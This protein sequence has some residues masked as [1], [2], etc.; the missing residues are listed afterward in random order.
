MKRRAF[1]VG[2]V[3]AATGGSALLGSGAVTESDAQR[4]VTIETVGDSDAP[5]RLAYRNQPVKCEEVIEVVQLTNH[6]EER[7]TDIEFS[8]EVSTD[9]LLFEVR[10]VPHSL[11]VGESAFVTGLVDCEADEPSRETVAFDI[12]I[13]GENQTLSVVDRQLRVTCRCPPDDEENP[14]R[15]AQGG[16]GNETDSG[17][18]DQ[19]PQHGPDDSAE[20]GA[21]DTRDNSTADR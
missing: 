21:D 11:S 10:E 5:L 13:T 8:Y 12:E 14:G 6:L 15:G 18:N 20:N 9:G 2:A 19:P 17:D 4:S 3:T 1:L 7:I 16:Q